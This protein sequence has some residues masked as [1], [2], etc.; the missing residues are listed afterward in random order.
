MSIGG[1]GAATG[2]STR[3]NGKFAGKSC[4]DTWTTVDSSY[5]G[6]DSVAVAKYNNLKAYAGSVSTVLTPLKNDLGTYGTEY[7]KLGAKLI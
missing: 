4:V 6:I 1:T 5:T 7:G 2:V 3:Y